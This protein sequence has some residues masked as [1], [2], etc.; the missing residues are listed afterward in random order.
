[1]LP[2]D[3]SRQYTILTGRK[4]PEVVKGIGRNHA[5]SFIDVVDKVLCHPF[6]PRK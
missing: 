2:S 5:Q 4:E 3:R 1:M 6:V